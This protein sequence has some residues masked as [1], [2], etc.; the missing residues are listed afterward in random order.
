MNKL[1]KSV[2]A[3]LGVFL[4]LYCN[5]AVST[6]IICTTPGYKVCGSGAADGRNSGC[7]PASTNCCTT[8]YASYDPSCKTISVCSQ[9]DTSCPTDCQCVSDYIYSGL[10]G[11]KCSK[12]GLMRACVYRCKNGYFKSGTENGVQNGVPICK[13]CPSNAIGQ[14][15]QCY[16]PSGY[17]HNTSTNTCVACPTNATCDDQQNFVC[18]KG[19]YKNGTSCSRCP[20]SGGVYGT[21]ASTGATSITSCYIP[22]GTTMSDST[23][24]YTYTSNCY[25]TK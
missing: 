5:H 20:S 24:K 23:G 13:A 9:I 21:T 4:C 11:A 10:Y 17:W 12:I 19:Y 16:C 14:D 6:T 8:Q 22:S 1:K 3:F 7:F 25:Y 15:G 2:I 18:N